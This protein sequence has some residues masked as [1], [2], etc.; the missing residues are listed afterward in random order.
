MFISGNIHEEYERSQ[1]DEMNNVSSSSILEY[2]QSHFSEPRKGFK[3]KSTHLKENLVIEI[4][5]D[6]RIYPFLRNF[7][8]FV[9]FVSHIYLRITLMPYMIQ[10]GLWVCKMNLI[11]LN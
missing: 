2:V 5:T 6:I 9:S 11:D 1:D 3:Y 4:K 10:I 7:Y 8:P